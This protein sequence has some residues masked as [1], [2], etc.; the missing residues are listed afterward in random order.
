MIELGKAAVCDFHTETDK[1]LKILKE[2]NEKDEKI[3][4][5]RMERLNCIK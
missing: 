3:Y 5:E 2:E 4:G 1:F